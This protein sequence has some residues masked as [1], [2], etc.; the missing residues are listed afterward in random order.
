MK[1]QNKNPPAKNQRPSSAHRVPENHWP[2]AIDRAEPPT[3][4]SGLPQYVPLPAAPK[5]A[6]PVPWLTSIHAI[7][8]RGDYGDPAYRG[9]CSG[10][11]IRD[12]L[13]Y[14]QPRRVLD[15]MTGG[16]TCRDVCRELEIECVSLD[17]RSGPGRR[18]TQRVLERRH[19]RFYLAPSALLENGSLERRPSLPGQRADAERFPARPPQRRAKLRAGITPRRR[20]GNSH[21]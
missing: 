16:G 19:V 14:H 1:T 5:T 15:P 20:A 13:L 8:G 3:A 11:L 6:S 17:I 21:G 2:A 12:L 7:P 10:L 18:S 9:N 4:T